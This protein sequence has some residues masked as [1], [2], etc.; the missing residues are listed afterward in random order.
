MGLPMGGREEQDYSPR[1][2]TLSSLA[3][4]VSTKDPAV[5]KGALG[6]IRRLANSMPPRNQAR[7]L[8]DLPETY[9]RLGDQGQAGDSVEE[10]IRVAGKL[11]ELDTDMNDPNQACNGMWP[12]AH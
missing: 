10:L 1:A 7:I 3:R 12:L 9:M 6:E 11:Y 2:S 4:I 8:A 5:S